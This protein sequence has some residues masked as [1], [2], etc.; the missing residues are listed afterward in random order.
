M[1][2]QVVLLLAFL[3]IINLKGISQTKSFIPISA[4]KRFALII[5]NKDYQYASSLKN[6]INDVEDI[7]ESLLRLGFE[8]QILKNADYRDIKESL[9]SFTNKLD[10]SAIALVYF[11][12]HGVSYSGK[13]YLLPIDAKINCLDHIDV[14]GVSLNLIISEISSKKVKNSFFFLDA[15]RNLPN[16]KVCD[17]SKKDL[18]GHNGLVMPTNNPEGSMIVYATEEGSTADDNRNERNGMFTG[19]LLKYLE[20]PNIGIRTI[21]DRTTRDV[22]LK[23]NKKQSPA[24]YDK[25]L[26]DFIFISKPIL[27]NKDSITVVISYKPHPLTLKLSVATIGIISGIIASSIKSNF[28]SK[29]EQFNTLDKTLPVNGYFNSQS[30]LDKWNTAYSDAQKAQKTA[31]LNAMVATSILSLGYELF[32]LTTKVKVPTRKTILRPSISN[33]SLGFVFTHKF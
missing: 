12:G 19:S 18:Q 13:N 33:T 8:V 25:L 11:S 26:G 28:D 23:T 17:D 14:Y 2:K 15:C 31:L 22:L 30:D 6:P 10:T 21:L 32:L 7:N 9:N 3:S 5:G 4:K 27:P 24:R 16:L 29:V 20:T 1:K